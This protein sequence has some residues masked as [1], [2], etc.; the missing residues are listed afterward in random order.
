M[1]GKVSNIH[2]YY[3]IADLFIFP[4]FSEGSPVSLLE[5]MASGLNIIASNVPGV[6][7]ILKNF[8]NKL[9]PAGDINSLR[10]LINKTF[11]KEMRNDTHL[12]D[13]VRINYNIDIETSRHEKIYGELLI[14]N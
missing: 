7:D 14:K 1:P 12:L 4:S 2:E 6:R 5:A 11:A 3:S 9:F 10:N 8:P 13:Y